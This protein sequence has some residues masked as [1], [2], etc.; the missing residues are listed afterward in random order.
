LKEPK[1]IQEAD[2]PG[3]II[4]ILVLCFLSACTGP[5]DLSSQNLVS[6]YRPGELVFHPELQVFHVHDSLSRL[7]VRLNPDELLFIRQPDDNFRAS[8]RV[9]IQ[10]LV[11]YENTTVKDTGIG[12]FLFEMKEKGK[13]KLFSV[14]FPVHASGLMLLHVFLMDM[15]KNYQ[16]DFYV[17]F[18]NTSKQV[19]Q[20]FL[21]RDKT[22][23]V[24]MR[25]YL[26]EK[27]TVHIRYSDSTI[28]KVFCKY[29]HR[30][31]NLAAPPYSLGDREEFNYH[32]DSIFSFDLSDSNGFVAQGE[33]F[34]HFQ[35][36]TLQKDGL[37]F[38]RFSP[39]F[40]NVVNPA[41]MLEAVR[42]LT[43]RKEFDELK[44]NP[45]KKTAVDRFW[46]DK[47][48]SAEKTKQLIKKYYSRVQEANK[49]FSSF[50]EGWR[51]DRGMIYTVFGSPSSITRGNVSES[52]VYG[53]PN[54]TL[55]LNLF[56]IKVRNPFSDND[57]ILSRSPVY[58]SNWFRA[59]DVW[60]QG[61]AYNAMY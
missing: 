5:R 28:T 19:R 20:R 53:S 35:I 3:R 55:A 1:K 12:D 60:R 48:G 42:Y 31:F 43:T 17:N 36:D 24:V 15:N 50:T 56:F 59:V 14:D 49:Y 51:T 37:T 21:V 30:N 4:I 16:E 9:K 33:G 13:M 44:S 2:M 58:E 23:E 8:L 38:Y 57:F 11:S 25:N 22:G 47:G 7:Y 26:S 61:R 29:Y 27:D 18:N 34:Y 54:S 46:L 52:W 10:L 40:P 41:E 6:L 39:G 45:N 32:P